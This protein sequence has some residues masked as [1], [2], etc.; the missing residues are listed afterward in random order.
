MKVIKIHTDGGYNAKKKI[1]SCGFVIV[2]NDKIIIESVKSFTKI[3]RPT[4]TINQMELLAVIDA[5]NWIRS[6]KYKPKNYIFYVYTDSQYVQLG[7]DKWMEKRKNSSG[8]NSGFWRD[9]DKL[10]QSFTEFTSLYVQWIESD[11]KDIYHQR[12]HE[13]CTIALKN[14]E[15]ETK[16]LK[17]MS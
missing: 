9:L 16:K 6:N 13:L 5:L 3:E 2:E 12:A 17:I 15:N 4:M 1:G 7:I 14:L 11:S 10:I 8:F